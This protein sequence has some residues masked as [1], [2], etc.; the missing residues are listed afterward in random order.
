MKMFVGQ[1]G[2]TVQ[3]R[4]NSNHPTAQIMNSAWQGGRSWCFVAKNNVALD[5]A[6]A[7][8]ALP[9][10]SHSNTLDLWTDYS[11][12]KVLEDEVKAAYNILPVADQNV[13]IGLVTANAK[14][15]GFFQGDGGF[16]SSGLANIPSNT[17]FTPK[18]INLGYLQP[19]TPSEVNMLVISFKAK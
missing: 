5:I 17:G 2:D 16:I 9:P 19:Y 7:K 15:P 1:K 11:M 6:V 8:V 14:I 10:V 13:I 3:I 4:G 18:F 12:E